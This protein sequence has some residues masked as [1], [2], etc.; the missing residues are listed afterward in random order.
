MVTYRAFSAADA[1]AVCT[2]ARS[3]WELTYAGIFT[4]E[5]IAGYVGQHYTPE[6]LGELL[7][8][9]ESGR[10]AFDVVIADDAVVGFCNLGLTRAGPELFRIYLL[11]AQIGRGIGTALLMRSEAFVRSHG[12]DAY[13]CYV[14]KANL[15]GRRFYDRQ[16]FQRLPKADHEDEWCL[17][18]RLR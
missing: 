1:A 6:R 12:F 9:I 15:I 8:L 5:F 10:M 13:R 7:P 14:H 2:V 16:G 11:P 3:A 17:M 4:P 18:K